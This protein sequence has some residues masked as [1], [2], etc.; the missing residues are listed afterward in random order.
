MARKSSVGV[1]VAG[2]VVLGGAGLAAWWFVRQRG[3]LAAAVD[4]LAGSARDAADLDLADD[5]VE[6]PTSRSLGDLVDGLDAKVRAML[7]DMRARGHSPYVYE[8]YR[9]PA[10]GDY[11]RSKGASKLGSASLHCQ[12]KAVDVVDGRKDSNGTRVFWGAAVNAGADAERASMAAEFFA[13]LGE[14][15]HAQGLVWGGDWSGFPDLAHVQAA[16]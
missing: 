12:G 7:D 14:A 13:D 2:V 6:T 10:R 9:S 5:D 4:S 1:A 8:T 11:L 15:A 16:S 3:G